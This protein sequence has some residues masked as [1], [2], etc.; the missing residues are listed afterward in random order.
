MPPTTP[1]S[2]NNQVKISCKRVVKSHFSWVPI[3]G[4]R[5]NDIGIFKGRSSQERDEVDLEAAE[6]AK[7]SPPPY[8]TPPQQRFNVASGS[9]SGNKRHDGPSSYWSQEMD[10]SV[11][12]IT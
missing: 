10:P 9:P 2:K 5:D 12:Y 4:R 7:S 8:R 3:E 11:G 1:Q 6:E